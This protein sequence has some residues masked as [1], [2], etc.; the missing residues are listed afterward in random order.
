[1][2]KLLLATR[3]PPAKTFTTHVPSRCC[4][5]EPSEVSIPH[6]WVPA[7][8]P[9]NRQVCHRERPVERSFGARSFTTR[10][11]ETSLV[12]TD[13]HVVSPDGLTSRTGAAWAT[14]PVKSIAPM[15]TPSSESFLVM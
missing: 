8:V 9:L 13:T 14:D 7:T 2:V 5:N 4:A 12:V 6:L 3:V 10:P 11:S 1:M 15:N